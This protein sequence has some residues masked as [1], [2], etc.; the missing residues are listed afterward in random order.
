MSLIRARLSFANVTAATAL[1]IA[2]GGAAFA[3]GGGLVGAG[4]SIHGCVA[5]S[6][7]LLVVKPDQRCPAR[8]AALTFSQ[9]GP[10]GATG[11]TG[12]Q[13]IQGQQGIA[14]SNGTDGTNGTNASVAGYSASALGAIDFKTTSLSNVFAHLTLPPGSYLLTAKS[15]VRATESG[16]DFIDATCVLFQQNGTSSQQD[17]SEFSVPLAQVGSTVYQAIGTVSMQ[18][19]V[20]TTAQTTWD[21]SCVANGYANSP[22]VNATDT[23][24][25]AI[26]LGSSN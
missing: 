22:T 19:A 1:F 10:R 11:A 8:T 17:S 6:K 9:T 14:G 16:P 2:L 12:A 26:T 18:L 25:E 3:A 21:E 13:G 5:R 23:R 24:L 15:V 7:A 20:T 4:G